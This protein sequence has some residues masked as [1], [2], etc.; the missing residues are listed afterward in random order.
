MNLRRIL[1]LFGKEVLQGPKN[2]MF[3][4]AFVIPVAVTLLI[5]LVFGTYF[6]S[7]SRLGI[8]DEGSSQVS[9]L[10]AENKALV[11]KQYETTDTLEKAVQR[12]VVDMGLVLPV[13]FDQKLLANDQAS[14]RVYVWGESPLDSRVVISAA[15]IRM[16]R[17]VS[18]QDLPV[19]I[20]QV[21]LG[22]A[23]NVPWETRLLPLLVLM[24]V[25]LAGTMIPAS[26]LVNEKNKR[27]LS[28]L[29]SSP[30]TLPEIYTSKGMLGVLLSMVT[31]LAILFLNRAFGGQ[32]G[33]LLLTL[34]LGSIFASAVGVLLGSLVK[35]VAGLFTIIKS[36]GIFLYAPGIIYMFPNLP[37]WIG[38]FFPTY[39]V[40]QPVLDITQNNASFADIWLS[41][42]LVVVFSLLV[43]V[44]IGFV[45]RRQMEAL[46]AV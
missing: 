30:A 5:S 10:A 24:A 43:M 23:T 45:S 20:Q 16:M 39:Y 15:I 33:L 29:N 8:A 44:L 31:A 11:V 6:S 13:D 12:G 18:G 34:L 22:D 32:A 19:D 4:F 28:A 7:T 17:Q 37:A 1:V 14:V 46:A 9:R 2:F 35:D 41:L 38:K 25:L 42:V 21:V 27:T 36:L 40:I 26:S 3:I